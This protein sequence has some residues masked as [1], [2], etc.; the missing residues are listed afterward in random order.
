MKLCLVIEIKL[1]TQEELL[2]HTLQAHLHDPHPTRP[3][4]AQVGLKSGP[5]V[6]VQAPCLNASRTYPPRHA[7]A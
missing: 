7:K 5:Q 6:I 3:L 1:K 4:V 2:E